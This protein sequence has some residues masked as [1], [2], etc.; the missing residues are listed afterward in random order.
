MAGVTSSCKECGFIIWD[1]QTIK[2]LCD[3]CMALPVNQRPSA[4][5]EA[6]KQAEEQRK[7]E[8]EAW[9]GRQRQNME[10]AA[11]SLRARRSEQTQQRISEIIQENKTLREDVKEL[12]RKLQ[13]VEEEKRAEGKSFL[14]RFDNLDIEGEL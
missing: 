4:K 8:Q 14:R 7:A 12:K 1:E 2:G 5:R 13:E 9:R 10:E 6:A 11:A 3:E